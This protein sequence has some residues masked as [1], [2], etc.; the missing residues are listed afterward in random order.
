MRHARQ[1]SFRKTERLII[2]III[3][4]MHEK[5]KNIF[6]GTA[7]GVS[8]E[9]RIAISVANRR[10]KRFKKILGDGVSIH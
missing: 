3:D 10:M 4:G 7:T 9:K 2:N 6:N 5:D 8:H 1:S